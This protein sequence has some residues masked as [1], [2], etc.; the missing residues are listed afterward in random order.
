MLIIFEMSNWN[1]LYKAFDKNRV[2]C[3]ILK[4]LREINT[5]IISKVF[6][7]YDKIIFFNIEIDLID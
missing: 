4:C 6:L 1:S 3:L 7:K 5:F 2:S